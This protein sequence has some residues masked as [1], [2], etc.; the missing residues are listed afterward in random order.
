MIQDVL[1][2]GGI[3][4]VSSQTPNGDAWNSDLLTVSE[5]PRFVPYAEMAAGNFS[6]ATYIDHWDVSVS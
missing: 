1:D 3:P 2:K 4:V 6:A 5:G